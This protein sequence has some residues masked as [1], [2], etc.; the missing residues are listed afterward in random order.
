MESRR[1]ILYMQAVLDG[2]WRVVQQPFSAQAHGG[3]IGPN[4]L[5]QDQDPR[6]VRDNANAHTF[7]C[8]RNPPFPPPRKLTA[9]AAG[10]RYACIK[11][12]CHER[13]Q[14]SCTI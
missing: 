12:T 11:H 7:A 4:L 13:Y 10:A 1:K 6:L 3:H 9:P 2:D 5:W 14:L 8:T